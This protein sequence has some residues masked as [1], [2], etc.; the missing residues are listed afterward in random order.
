MSA[1]GA[2]P[3]TAS[4]PTLDPGERPAG[5]HPH[6]RRRAPGLLGL[7]VALAAAVALVAL[8]SA[9]RKPAGTP[10]PP[11][12]EAAWPGA[13]RADLPGSLPDGPAYS[14]V[15]FLDAHSSLGTAPSPDGRQLRLVR[16]DA[17]GGVR[18]LRRLPLDRT[19]QFSGFT[20]SGDEFAW[21]E[22]TSDDRGK[23][24]TELWAVDLTSGRPPRRVT[25]E[26]GDVI[27]FNSRYDLLIEAGRL[28]WV[29]VAPGQEPATELR[30]VP[31]GGGAVTVRTERGAWALSDWP[32]L[33]SAGTGTSGPVRLR[34][35][36]ARKVLDVDAGPTELVTC[37][38]V[39]CRAIVLGSDGPS[40]IDL[41]R[42]DGGDRRRVAGGSATAAVID[43]AVL[44]RF[45]VLTVAD[46]AGT[47]RT[48]SQQ[49]LLYDA[50]S[51]RTVVVAT[52]AGLVLARGGV[53]WWSTG[54]DEA[55]AWHTLDLTTLQ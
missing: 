15:F 42:P 40:R 44:D 25:A 55:L 4:L 32:W 10:A 36:A 19:P 47:G 14:P 45:E 18:E 38:P 52:A 13:Q 49:L 50:A 11:T 31:L 7:A 53:L 24:R 37:S 34:D 6:G 43:V 46:P 1:G 48:D 23:A 12:V 26:T 27:F 35:L 9:A 41:M 3:T 51:Q 28:Y 5:G 33:V 20:R 29:A 2:A 22:S 17:D 8:P 39:W 54:D 30:S 16:R 21:A